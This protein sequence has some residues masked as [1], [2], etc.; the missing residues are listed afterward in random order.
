MAYFSLQKAG[1][2]ILRDVPPVGKRIAP[3]SSVRR[4]VTPASSAERLD[5]HLDAYA[6]RLQVR[7]T[8]RRGAL[9]DVT[10][11][12]L[13]RLDVRGF[14]MRGDEVARVQGVEAWAYEFGSKSPEGVLLVAPG[15]VG[16]R[17]GV[18]VH[19]DRFSYRSISGEMLEILAVARMGSYIPVSADLSPAALSLC[20]DLM[21]TIRDEVDLWSRVREWVEEAMVRIEAVATAIPANGAAPAFSAVAPQNITRVKTPLGRRQW[22][23]A[24]DAAVMEA[25][26]LLRRETRL[27]FGVDVEA[28]DVEA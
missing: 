28:E 21:A 26:D 5:W 10:Y 6:R 23:A 7:E 3:A 27:F 12:E 11:P 13:D 25:R 19:G 15:G 16:R 1:P 24:A 2:R 20:V 17:D 9:V 4:D 22:S 18:A 14:A 8:L